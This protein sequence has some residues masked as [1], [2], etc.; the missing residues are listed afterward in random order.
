MKGP[1]RNKLGGQKVDSMVAASKEVAVIAIMG[2]NYQPKEVEALKGKAGKNARI[3]I[4]GDGEEGI[5]ANTLYEELA[6][7]HIIPHATV[8]ICGHVTL[9]PKNG[10]KPYIQLHKD[11]GKDEVNVVL[12]LIRL[13]LDENNKGVPLIV[14]LLT[15]YSGAIDQEAALG[16][17]GKGSILCTHT[18]G[19][20]AS[21]LRENMALVENDVDRVLAQRP[22]S[23]AE[24]LHAFFLGNAGDRL[25]VST[26]EVDG[27]IKGYTVYPW[28]DKS[29]PGII[30]DKS[31]AKGKSRTQSYVNAC[32]EALSI[33]QGQEDKFWE[34][35][36]NIAAF[37]K[38]VVHATA[39]N[40][41]VPVLR[42][43]LPILPSDEIKKCE[44]EDKETLI[45]VAM[46]RPD[47]VDFQDTV[48]LL[49]E[50]KADIG[51][52]N[53]RGATPV[54]WA[55]ENAGHNKIPDLLEYKAPMDGDKIPALHLAIGYAG[56]GIKT[57]ENIE[58]AKHLISAKADIHKS[59]EKYGTPNA[60]VLY[61]G[62]PVMA[63]LPLLI[64]NG[65]HISKE[66]A[67]KSLEGDDAGMT[68]V[69]YLETYNHTKA[70]N[71]LRS[72][73]SVR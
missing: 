32:L 72:Q 35:K 16:I 9:D 23:I 34:E 69:Q 67:H 54:Y 43:I 57:K 58:A 29:L 5:E 71:M 68:P 40:R 20:T 8:V 21:M 64:E 27:G 2:H 26:L 7:L 70:L 22:L 1:I 60:M 47:R 13:A 61:Y 10:N 48:R 6:S 24:P 36:F 17:L 56:C 3:K 4:L 12:E 11:A 19:H 25:E 42:A 41:D 18:H 65:A 45:H 46:R 59:V 37:R 50:H 53:G 55:I 33:Q 15:C 31:G 30:E 63:L 52:A 51:K 14:K 73:G 44:G 49:C 28:E 39:Y 38:G 62:M 66:D